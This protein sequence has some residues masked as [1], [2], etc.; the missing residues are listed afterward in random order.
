[1]KQV[2]LYTINPARERHKKQRKE[3]TC[4]NEWIIEVEE[5]SRL[6]KGK[7]G[8][9]WKEQGKVKVRRAR[10]EFREINVGKT[11]EESGEI[12]VGKTREEP[13]G[14]HVEKGKEISGE[15]NVGKTREELGE[16]M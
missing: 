11:R 9:T 8:K 1:M 12:N 6:S 5:I 4:G 14:I 13:E 2:S 3:I 15:M 7:L 16:W 10:E